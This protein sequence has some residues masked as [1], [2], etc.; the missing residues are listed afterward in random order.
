MKKRFVLPT[1]LIV[2]AL[3]FSG[4]SNLTPGENAGVFGG[5]AGAATGIALG[6]SGVPSY[7][8]IP[9]AIGAGALVASTAYIIA[10]HQAS[11][12]Q[13]K[14]AEQRARLYYAELDAEQKAEMKK[15]KVRYIAVDTRKDD[16]IEGE[17]AVM[18]FDTQN[19]Q[20]VGNNVYDVKESPTVGTTAKFDTYNAQ[21]VGSGK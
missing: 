11:V 12:E 9:V 16:R 1:V 20:I 2:S 8:T 3:G 4:C 10:K 14:I 7:V 18:V 5:L 19:Q 21:Y 13:Q 6:A 17:K 15:K